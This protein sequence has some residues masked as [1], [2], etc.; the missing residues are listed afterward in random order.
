LDQGP[1]AGNWLSRQHKGAFLPDPFFIVIVCQ[2][3]YHLLKLIRFVFRQIERGNI[4][5]AG[6][7]REL[8]TSLGDFYVTYDR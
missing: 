2:I 1:I 6:Y 3:A 4:R 7:Y 5:A 8:Q